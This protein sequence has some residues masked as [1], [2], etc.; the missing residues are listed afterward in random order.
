MNKAWISHYIYVG[1]RGGS[2]NV[3]VILGGLIT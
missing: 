1:G 2:D 3:D